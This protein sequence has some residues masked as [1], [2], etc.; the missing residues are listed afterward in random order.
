MIRQLKAKFPNLR[1]VYLSS[2]SY[3]GYATVPINPEPYAFETAFAVRGLIR[4]QI[5]GKGDLN[6][7]PARGPVKAPVLLW[8]PYLWADGVKGRKAGD[9]VWTRA[10]FARDG[11]HMSPSGLKKVAELLLRFFKTDPTAKDW[12]RKSAS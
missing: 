3:G 8:G 5:D 10:D 12:F 7:D 6:F 1:I 9:L 11:T 2:R 4:D